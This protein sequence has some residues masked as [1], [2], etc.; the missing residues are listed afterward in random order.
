MR[1][2]FIIRTILQH[3]SLTSCIGLSL[4]RVMLGACI[5]FSIEWLDI[6]DVKDIQEIID[7]D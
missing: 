6:F 2:I 5:S 3:L 7:T 4:L 1:Q